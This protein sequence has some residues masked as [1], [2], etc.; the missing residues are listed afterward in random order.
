MKL[1][2]F[3]AVMVAVLATASIASAQTHTPYI[4][5]RQHAEDHRIN[6]GVRNGEI[7]HREATH[8]RNNERR[9]AMAKHNA[10]RNGYVSPRE[11][12]HIMRM[13][14]RNSRAI[15]RAKHNGRRY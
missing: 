1:K 13:E 9:I 4:N 12:R 6:Q 8:L 7:T 14:N 3:G 10:R 11:R 2:I 15:Y 5:Q